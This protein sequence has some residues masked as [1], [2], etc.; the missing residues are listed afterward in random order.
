VGNDGN[1]IYHSGDTMVVDPMGEVLY[2]NS[3]NEDVHTITIEKNKL[4]EVRE[5][6]PFWKD[7]DHFLLV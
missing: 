5:K 3:H 4:K 7:G 6:L 2:Q 1:Q